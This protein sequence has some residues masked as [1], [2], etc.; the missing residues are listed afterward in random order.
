MNHSFSIQLLQTSFTEK[1]MS[2]FSNVI[3]EL[4]AVLPD[5]IGAILILLIGWILS[6]VV[7]S[8]I[9]K[10][11]TKIGLDKLADKLNETETF[12]ENH[13]SVKPV[14]IIKNFIYWVLM[15]IFI[16]SAAETIGLN[17]VTEQVGALIAYLP[18]LFT[19]F[20][21]LAIGFYIADAIKGMIARS[22]KT[23]GISAW[24]A[25]SN[26]VFYILLIA[27]IITSL[28]Q[29]GINTDIITSNIYIILGGVFL[30]FAIA[31]GF[32][33]RNVLSSILTSFYTRGNFEVGQVISIDGFKGQIVKMTNV[34]LTL[35]TGKEYVVFPLS[36]L[37]NDKVIIHQEKLDFNNFLEE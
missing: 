25:M 35:F 32:A 27:I 37:I 10:V 7:S 29:A 12:T 28:N 21:I 14:G 34:S 3:G 5:L 31:Y 24:R 23:F 9:A 20:I 19:A 36:R 22:A 30:A 11:L 15:L 13:I 4:M 26:G 6:K 17:I 18:K 8:I 2:S 1:I 33:A 16:L